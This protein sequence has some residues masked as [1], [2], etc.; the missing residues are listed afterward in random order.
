[1]TK[2]KALA[3]L[4]AGMLLVPI[5][6][7]HVRAASDFVPLFNG[8]DLAGWKIPAGDNGHWR[9]VDSVIDYDARR[10]IAS[11]DGKNLALEN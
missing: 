7:L 11:F 9:V 10:E 8:R 5:A 4:F 2:A 1:M 3:S 6:A